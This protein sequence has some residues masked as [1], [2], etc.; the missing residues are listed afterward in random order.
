MTP[1]AEFL[2]NLRDD[3]RFP[4][5]VVDNLAAAFKAMES[6]GYEVD[7]AATYLRAIEW[8]LSKDN[9]TV[10]QKLLH[11]GRLSALGKVDNLNLEE[12]ISLQ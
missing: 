12:F 10:D 7:D 5:D 8:I 6:E 4:R 11:I 1:A 9:L 3:A 2:R